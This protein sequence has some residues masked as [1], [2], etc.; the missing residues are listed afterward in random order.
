MTPEV[1]DYLMSNG[2]QHRI[3]EPHNHS[4]GT[5]LAEISIRWIKRKMDMAFE[6]AFANDHLIKLGYLNHD[7][8]S[9]WG[10]V[11]H[12]AVAAM[13]CHSCPNDKSKTRYE[14]FWGSRPNLQQIR[15]LP[16]FSV[17]LIWRERP[18]EGQAQNTKAYVRALYVGPDFD[19]YSLHG[20]GA[21]R[22]FVK[23]ESGRKSVI[24]TSKYT[25]VS[26]GG[27]SDIISVIYKGMSKLLT[28]DSND[29]LTR[30]A[31]DSR[32]SED[33]LEDPYI[34]SG[35]DYSEPEFTD[36]NYDTDDEGEGDDDD[37]PDGEHDNTEE[38][39]HMPHQPSSIQAGNDMDG[40][41]DTTLPLNAN[42]ELGVDL[43]TE[44]NNHF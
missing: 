12:W 10:E 38:R 41:E 34:D 11:F 26:Q 39:F 1:V 32:V 24:C 43:R 14:V 40:P 16:I 18:R 13:N 36:L 8:I 25:H 7:I 4:N 6:Y 2:M 19:S 31:E 35:Y 20:S 23:H 3:A 27:E 33:F 37:D 15:F 44:S 5:P 17:V 21:I 30:E 22:V 28:N 9:L 29:N 42:S